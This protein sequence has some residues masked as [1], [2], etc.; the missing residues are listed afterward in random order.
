[1]EVLHLRNVSFEDAGEYTCLAGNSIGISHHS[2]WL[3]VLEGIYSFS[4]P[5]PPSF[6]RV[7]C[8]AA[9]GRALPRRVGKERAALP[10]PAMHTWLLL[11]RVGPGA[12][13]ASRAHAGSG[14][15]WGGWGCCPAACAPEELALPRGVGAHRGCRCAALRAHRCC[16][17]PSMLPGPTADNSSQGKVFGVLPAPRLPAK[18]FPRYQPPLGVLRGGGCRDRRFPLFASL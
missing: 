16:S 10:P 9:G 15:L 6:P 8:I 1:M 7:V 3:T 12:R 13:P 11:T 2:A 18:N 5:F 17:C 4:C 14:G